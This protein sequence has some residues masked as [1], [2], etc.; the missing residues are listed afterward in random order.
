[1][2][3]SATSEVLASSR[4]AWSKAARGLAICGAAFSWFHHR[5][6]CAAA[7]CFY[8]SRVPSRGRRFRIW[9]RLLALFWFRPRAHWEALEIR[10][11][12]CGLSSLF[13]AWAS[14]ETFGSMGFDWALAGWIGMMWKA[15]AFGVNYQLFAWVVP[16]ACVERIG[17]LTGRSFL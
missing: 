5:G 6:G 3:L 16:R 1:M 17:N 9:R 7:Y 4:S 12:G 8:V 2:R 10:L 15:D 14:A 13:A 11:A